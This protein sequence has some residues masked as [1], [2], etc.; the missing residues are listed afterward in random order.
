[1][2]HAWCAATE[3]DF[4]STLLGGTAPLIESI[5]DTPTLDAWR[6]APDDSLAA[7]ADRVN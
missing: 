3:I 4:D 7:D 1:V 2:D 6:L 5:L